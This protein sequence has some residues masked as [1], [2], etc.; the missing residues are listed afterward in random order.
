MK[1]ENFIGGRFIQRRL[2]LTEVKNESHFVPA[3]PA[4]V[5]IAFHP[6]MRLFKLVLSF[7]INR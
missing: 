4:S 6:A 3:M 5:I 7:L 1:F 2:R